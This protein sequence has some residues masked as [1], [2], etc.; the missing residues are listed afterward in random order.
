MATK[1]KIISADTLSKGKKS[2]T[3]KAGLN[4]DKVKD[5]VVDNK[6]LI[7]DVAEGFLGI[8]IDGDGKIG[9]SKKKTT[10]KKTTKKK[11]EKDSLSTVI[12]LV[13]T[14]SSNKKK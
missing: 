5:L 7:E 3:K 4:I 8:D 6:D 11:E 1:K 13:Q 2:T 14:F 12:D 9:T 10:K